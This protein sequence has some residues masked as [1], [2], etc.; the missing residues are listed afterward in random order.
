MAGSG[1]NKEAEEGGAT[2]GGRSTAQADS[3]LPDSR[4]WTYIQRIGEDRASVTSVTWP[5]EA[6]SISVP[7]QY[8]VARS[9]WVSSRLRI[10]ESAPLGPGIADEEVG[11]PQA[12]RIVLDQSVDAMHSN[13]ES[14]KETCAF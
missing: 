10:I 14:W 5:K 3:G 1:D 4:R 2:E 9:V 12:R 8:R 13:P 6:P 7:P 11:R